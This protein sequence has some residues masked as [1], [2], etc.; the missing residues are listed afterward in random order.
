[1]ENAT[2]ALVIAANVLLAV[3]I[4]SLVVYFYGTW[5]QLP[6]EED[7][8]K[9]VAQAQAFN[10]EYEAYDKKI[11]YGADVISAINKAI[12]NNEKYIQGSWLS[13]TLSTTEFAVNVKV[14]IAS[15]LEERVVV[16]HRVLSNGSVTEY[17][18]TP[19]DLGAGYDPSL[20]PDGNIT[21]GDLAEPKDYIAAHGSA[22]DRQYINTSP[23][24]ILPVDDYKNILDVSDDNWRNFNTFGL[25]SHSINVRKI[26]KDAPEWENTLG[27][28]QKGASPTRPGDNIYVYKLLNDAPD[29]PKKEDIEKSQKSYLRLLV[30]GITAF[31]NAQGQ[32]VNHVVTGLSDEDQAKQLMK[33]TDESGTEYRGWSSMTWKPAVIDL[34]T[35]K[36]KCVGVDEDGIPNGTPGIHYNER[37][38]AIDYLTFVEYGIN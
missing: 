27:E 21:L 19:V 35:R 33:Y 26:A 29:H 17:E 10:K 14:V 31:N 11:M 3:M 1:M 28:V 7:Q 23:K 25:Y 9:L 16:R 5:R 38:G 20:I 6:Q 22:F 8:A 32:T 12:S 36:F 24:F 18:Y 15:S 34:K 2:K 30:S 4:L 13:G 37:T